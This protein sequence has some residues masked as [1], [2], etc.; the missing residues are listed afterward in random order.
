MSTYAPQPSGGPGADAG[1]DLRLPDYSIGF[2][3]AVRRGFKKYATFDGRASRA[4]FW[5]WYLFVVG[6]ALVLAVPSGVIAG[7]TASSSSDGAPSPVAAIGF[8]LIGVFYLAVLV[9]TLAVAC[10]RLHDAGF[11]GLFLL[12][13]LVTGLVPLIMCILPTSPNAVRFGPPGEPQPYGLPSGYAP[14]RATRRRPATHP[15]TATRPRAA[16]R[17]RPGPR[18]DPATTTSRA[19]EPSE[20]AA[21]L[22]GMTDL[23]AGGHGDQLDPVAEAQ[24]RGAGLAQFFL[25]DPQAWKGPQV[26]YEGGAAALRQAATDAGVA[27]YVHA[28]YVLNVATTNNRIRIPS[29]KFLQQHLD[30]AAEIGAAGLVVHGGHVLKADDPALGHR[31]L[32]Q[33][34]RAARPGR[35]AAHREHGGRRQRDGPPPRPARPAVGRRRR[36]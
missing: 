32:A 29:R 33:V 1:T 27:L 15:R 10:R 8:V 12:L 14:S 11:S 18:A 26:A 2:A 30:A 36:R 16:T 35:A 21:S 22:A 17:R 20:P 6:G 5:F 24:A 3:G 7:A 4:E 19:A 25:G 13:G 31:Q 23:L 34:R 9:P 28:P